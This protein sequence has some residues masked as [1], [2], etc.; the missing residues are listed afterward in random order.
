MN[1]HEGPQ[2]ASNRASNTTNLVPGMNITNEPGIYREG[3]YGIRIE[4]IMFVEEH[5]ENE[6]GT[7]YKLRSST[8][9]PIN[10]RPI[11]RDMLLDDEVKW[12]NDYHAQVYKE[13]NPYLN[14]EEQAW[15]KEN[16]QPI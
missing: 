16:T 6:F 10:T 11:K 2:N 14:E 12:I 8:M 15:L 5:A 13:L 9:C 4:N 3:E 7:F 1:V